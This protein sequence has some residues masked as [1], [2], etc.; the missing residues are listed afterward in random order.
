[1][2]PIST[3]QKVFYLCLIAIAL[4][5][6][7]FPVYWMLNTALK[8]PNE[9]LTNPP[10]FYPHR[11][12]FT[13]FSQALMQ[14]GGFKGLWDSLVVSVGATALS[15]V[16]GVMGAYAIARYKTGGDN[17]SFFVLSVLFFPP[18]VVSIPMF[19]F[20]RSLNL[21]DTFPAMIVQ[22][23]SF[24]TPFVTWILKG[25]FEDL[26]IELEESAMVNGAGRWHAF[27]DVALPSVKGAIV[28]TAL[29][30]FI[31]SWNAFTFATILSQGHIT[32]L[33]Y[34]LPTLMEGHY[35]LW[36]DIAAIATVAVIPIVI[37]AFLLQKYLV[38]GLSFGTVRENL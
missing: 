15:L 36:G 34:I 12:D 26:P 30:A 21:I 2:K 37:L 3:W 23:S 9:W 6:F 11:L 29:L 20:W 31:F 28:A 13:N 16:G 5:F 33:P 1:M 38:R 10:I 7:L 8:P 25:F 27:W 14:W 4:L 19:Q 24:T 22:Y 17:F 18:V 32:T 35:V